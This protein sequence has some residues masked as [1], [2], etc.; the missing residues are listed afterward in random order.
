MMQGLELKRLQFFAIFAKRL[1]MFS[2]RINLYLSDDD[3]FCFLLELLYISL[4]FYEFAT[5]LWG[6]FL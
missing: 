6:T 1:A 3:W 2:F 4:G 5:T